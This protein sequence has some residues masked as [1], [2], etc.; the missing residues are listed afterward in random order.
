MHRLK[1]YTIILC[2]K[3]TNFRHKYTQV[4]IEIM[5]ENVHSNSFTFKEFYKPTHCLSHQLRREF[6]SHLLVHSNFPAFF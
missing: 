5:E 6:D 1:K 4:E 2:L 3:V